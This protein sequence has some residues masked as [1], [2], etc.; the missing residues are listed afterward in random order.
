M[1]GLGGFNGD[2]GG[3]QVSDLTDHN[4]IRILAQE[5]SE[6]GSKRQTLFLIDVDL[7]DARQVNLGRILGRRNV[8]IFRV[9]NTQAGIE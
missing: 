8:H 3:F 4:N 6:C 1:A 9:Q 7:V 2:V 5:G